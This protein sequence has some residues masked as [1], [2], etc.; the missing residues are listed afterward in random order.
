MRK[1]V[2]TI[3]S[4]IACSAAFASADSTLKEFTGKYVFPD[5]SVVNEVGI[6]LEGNDLTINAPIGSSSLERK[7]GDIFSITQFSGTAVFTR[8]ASK[9][10]IGIVIDAMGYHLEGTKTTSGFSFAVTR[11]KVLKAA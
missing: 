4:L 9:K 10:I 8:D 6:V 3:L 1:I 7:E 2:F 11:K 5:G